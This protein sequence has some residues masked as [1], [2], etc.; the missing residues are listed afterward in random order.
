MQSAEGGTAD[1]LVIK[2]L[3]VV[4]K[5]SLINW[6]ANAAQAAA[7]IGIGLVKLAITGAPSKELCSGLKKG[8]RAGLGYFEKASAVGKLAVFA[9]LSCPS[10][11][12]LRSRLRAVR[13]GIRPT[14]LK[15]VR[16]VRPGNERQAAED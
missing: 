1:V 8:V 9:S 15:H 7:S 16:P 13:R 4:V 2:E 6:K 11:D 14:G 3:V 12:A 10:L 5:D